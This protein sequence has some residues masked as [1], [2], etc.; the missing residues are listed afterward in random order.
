[1]K[2]SMAYEL[3]G[4]TRSRTKRMKVSIQPKAITVCVPEPA[5]AI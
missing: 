1:M 4:G 5:A 3:D 2:P